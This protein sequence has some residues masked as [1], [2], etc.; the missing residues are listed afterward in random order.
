MVSK[1]SSSHSS[2]SRTSQA[3]D[4]ILACVKEKKSNSSSHSSGSRTSHARDSIFA[5]GKKK[6]EVRLRV[7]QHS[8]NP[9]R[10]GDGNLEIANH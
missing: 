4:S 8:E 6:V 2:G 9:A 7:E 10:K 3:R 1:S 5:R